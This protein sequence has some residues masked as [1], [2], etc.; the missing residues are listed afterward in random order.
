MKNIIKR[1]LSLA[2]VIISVLSLAVIPSNAESIHDILFDW[3]YYYASNPDVA[4]AFG[5]NPSALKNH[6]NNH[7]K[8]EGRAPSELFDPKV[9]IGLYPDLKAAFGS[10]YRAA[11]DHFVSCGINEG[12]QGSSKFSI[13]VYKANYADLRNAFG[14]NNALYFKHYLQY[15]KSE[16]R[17][18]VKSVSTTKSASTSKS[19]SSSASTSFWQFP[20]KNYTTT[21][22]FGKNGHLG[23]DIKSNSKTVY[24]AASGR[25]VAVGLNGTGTDASATS[26]PKGNGYY[27]VIQHNFNGKTVYTMYG[28]LKKNSIKVSVNQTVSKGM[29]I[30][31]IGNTGRSTGAHLHFAIANTMKNGSYYGYTSDSKTFSSTSKRESRSGVTFYDPAYVINN[32]KLG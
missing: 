11:Y 13:S 8:A 14:N 20:V 23:I 2:L 19:T 29:E 12:R 32:G 22:K 5:R 1:T 30:A 18:A 25:V 7:G 16:G 27:I 24:A 21:Q 31:T 15:G 10:N 6:Y 28:H 17:N 3:Q 9:Y 4:R 26:N